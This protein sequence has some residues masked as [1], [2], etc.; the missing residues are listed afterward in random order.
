MQPIAF[1]FDDRGR[2]WVV[3]CLSYPKWRQDGK[4]NDRVVILEDTDGDGTHDKKTVFLDNGVEPLRHRTRLRRR[5]ALLVAEPRVRPRPRQDDKPDGPPEVMLDGW[6]MKDTKHNVFNSCWGPDGWLYGCNGIQAKAWVGKPGTP[7]KDRVVHRLRRVALP[8]DAEDVRGGRPRH[9]QPVRPRLGRLRRD[10]H[11]QLRDRPPVPRRPRRAL[12]ADVRPGR[13]PAHLRADEEL[14][15]PQALGRRRL[16]EFAHDRRRRRSRSTATPAAA[17]PT[18]GCAIYLG[19]N[20]PA[21]YRNTLFTCNIHG[22]RLNH[23]GLERTRSG[24]RRRAR[25][26]TSCSPT[27][28]GSAASA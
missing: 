14:R 4:G 28:R 20:F 16:D 1:T 7:D 2:M 12:R 10:V 18:A 19:D 26:R 25:R 22:N 15:R 21:E 8:P 5:V 23:D 27:T 11:H 24:L 13:E 9:D 6:N 17:T 3:E